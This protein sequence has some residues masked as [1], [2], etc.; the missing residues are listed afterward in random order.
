MLVVVLSMSILAV[1]LE[2]VFTGTEQETLDDLGKLINNGY[3][4]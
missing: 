4:I 1:S 2:F 3:F